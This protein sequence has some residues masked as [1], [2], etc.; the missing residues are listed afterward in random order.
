MNPELPCSGPF[1]LLRLC[2]LLRA[3]QLCGISL[4]VTP[5]DEEVATSTVSVRIV[6]DTKSSVTGPHLV[7]IHILNKILFIVYQLLWII[8]RGGATLIVVGG[9]ARHQ[10]LVKTKICTKRTQFHRRL[11][12]CRQTI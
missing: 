7:A 10:L 4:L 9:D 1:S 6:A 8:L 5:S 11:V 2:S 3:D 12:R